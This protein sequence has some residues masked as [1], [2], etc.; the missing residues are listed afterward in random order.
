[1]KAPNVAIV[2]NSYPTK[3]NETNQIFIKNLVAELDRRSIITY[4][5]YNPI[6]NYWGNA[7]NSKNLFSNIIKYSFF[8]IGIFRLIMKIK[9]YDLLNPH[10]VMPSGFVSV[11]IKRFFNIPVAI[12]VHGGDLNLYKS[13]NMIYKKIYDHTISNSDIVIVNSNNI[14]RKLLELTNITPKNLAVISP[15]IDYKKFYRMDFGK[16]TEHKKTYGIHDD[17]TVLLFAG[18][19]I[20]RKGLDILVKALNL[21]TTE[22]L[23]KIFLIICSEGPEINTIRTNLDD[24]IGIKD[25]VVFLKKVDQPTLNILYNIATVF[26]FPSR[27]EPL[28][29]VGLESIACGTPVIG[30]NIGGIPEY[31]NK[32]NGL[33]FDPNE[34]KELASI[35]STI[36]SDQ[37]EIFSFNNNIDKRKAEHDINITVK[38]L[39]DIFCELQVNSILEK[40]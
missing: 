17:K 25:S 1:M 11:L 9:S 32:N 37:K 6:Y 10:G 21:L 31:I 33:L 7:S 27:E 3:K 8:T 5:Y 15:G 30:S 36:L 34:P 18:N 16:I 13:S 14:K 20:K 26:I 2:C 12:H 28:G 40:D 39:I 35:V 24:I 23:E 19:A 38:R 22:E 4:V 29:L